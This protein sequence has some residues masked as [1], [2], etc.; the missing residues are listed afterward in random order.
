MNDVAVFEPGAGTVAA[1]FTVS[2]SAASSATVTVGY[3]TS[4]NTAQ[5]PG[6]YQPASGTLTFKPGDT[7]QNITVL[8]NDDALDEPDE[9]YFVQLFGAVNATI[10]DGL[11]VGTILDDDPPPAVSINDTSVVEGNSG[12]ADAAFTVQLSAPSGKVVAVNFATADGTAVAPGDYQPLSGSVVFAPGET[13]Q[14]I[15]VAVNGDTLGEANETFL[16]NLSNPID[17]TI[18]DGQ[19]VGRI[20]NDD[21]TPAFQNRSVTPLVAEGTVATLTGTVVLSSPTDVFLMQVEW[22]DGTPTQHV[23]LPAGSNGQVVTLNHTYADNGPTGIYP[24]HVSWQNQ[25]GGGNS[26]DFAVTV[27]NVPPT[28]DAGPDT[29]VNHGGVLNRTGSFHDPG[30]DTWVATVDFGDG[31]GPQAL[32][33]ARDGTFKLHYKYRDPGVYRV[34]VTVL[35]DDGG[36]GTASFLVT[37]L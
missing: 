9:T 25:Y 15:H 24:V 3:T 18:A 33:L 22:G 27:T 20:L 29:T 19:G 12:T 32:A 8:V 21:P 17:A 4:D 14:T 35:D 30:A 13:T 2:L 34:T 6:D 36:A 26:A 37:V 1:Q 31:S 16:V 11:G 5:A 28:V 23:A 10:A 7:T